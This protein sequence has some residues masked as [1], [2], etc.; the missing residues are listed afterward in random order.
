MSEPTLDL[1]YK[2]ENQVFS[3]EVVC[4]KHTIL[5]PISHTGRLFQPYQN[6]CPWCRVERAEARVEKLGGIV[7]VQ[8][9]SIERLQA[10]VKELEAATAATA[11][12]T[13]EFL[14]ES[15]FIGEPYANDA[16]RVLREEGE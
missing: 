12:A 2:T 4:K 11:L 10:R 3:G 8:V 15:G 13:L 14:I 16:R 1:S 7:D 9:V 6:I 5:F